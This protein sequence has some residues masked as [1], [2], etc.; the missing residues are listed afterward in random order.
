[1]LSLSSCQLTLR[2][3]ASTYTVRENEGYI[4]VEVCLDLGRNSSGHNATNVNV[5]ASRWTLYITSE[6]ESASEL[7]SMTQSSE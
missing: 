2:F 4:L 1:M 3:N 5:T 6:E 7:Y